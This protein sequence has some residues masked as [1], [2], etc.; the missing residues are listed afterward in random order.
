MFRIH[1]FPWLLVGH[2]LPEMTG[3][4]TVDIGRVK[5]VELAPWQV[6]KRG[7]Y[8]LRRG[9]LRRVDDIAQE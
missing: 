5:E 6:A 1:R 7:C 2:L 9:W 8:R 3:M 4:P